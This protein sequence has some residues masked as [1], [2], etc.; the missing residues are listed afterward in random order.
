MTRYICIHG[1]FYQPPRENPWLE[2]VE[3]QD[4]ALPFH[5]WNERIT[6]ECYAPNAKSRLM[7]AHGKVRDI[8]S[9]YAKINFNFGP[10]LLAW[11]EKQ[12]P[13]AYKEII[14]S[15][16]ESM[17]NFGGHPSAIAQVYNHMIM[18][19]ANNRDKET[20]VAWG[21]RDYEKRF[22]C[23]PEGMWLAETAVDTPT[24]EVLAAYGIKYTILSQY[25][26]KR[27]RKSHNAEWIDAS[28]GRLDP[29]MPYVQ[30]LPSGRQIALFF[31][32]GPIS[33]GIA[34]DGLL[35]DG[36]KLSDRLLGA[37]VDSRKHPQLVHI[38][39]DGETYGH[40][41]Q[42]GE[43]AL[44]FAIDH[45]ERNKLAKFVNY[46]QFLELHPP[47]AE[48]EIM[49]NSSWS[50]AH[51]VERWRSNCGCNTGGRPSW[52]QN[53]RAPLRAALDFLRDTVALSFETH[54]KQYLRNPWFARDSY[55]DVMLDRS[56]DNIER[57][58]A[59]HA[60]KQLS[61]NEKSAVLKLLELQRH[62]MLM[63]TSCGW[64]FDELG[65]IETVQC[66]QYAG[67]VVQ[68]AHELFPE[69]PKLEED[70]LQLLVKAKGNTQPLT[71]GAV[72]Y[73]TCV[74]PACLDFLKVAAHHAVA[75]IFDIPAAE[76]DL[77]SYR[78]MQDPP[79]IREAGK[80]TF[81]LGK[82]FIINT[83]TLEKASVEFGALHFGDHTITAGVRNFV[84]EHSQKAL[85]EDALGA[86]ERLDFPAVL[87]VFEKHFGH[88]SYSLKSLFRD[89]QRR[90]TYKLLAETTTDLNA[91]YSKTYLEHYTL[92]RF[93]VE[94]ENRLPRA[95]SSIANFVT[96]LRIRSCLSAEK[97]DIS[98]LR[99]TMEDAKRWNFKYD[100]A[101]FSHLFRAR[102][103][104]LMGEFSEKPHNLENL[105]LLE[106]FI[107][108][109]KTLPFHVNLW[110]VQNDYFCLSRNAYLQYAA[111]G[112]EEKKPP[113]AWFALFQ[114]L[115]DHLSIA[116]P[117]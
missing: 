61:H 23:K 84:C 14:E 24:L 115:G 42:F 74:K 73:K 114:A 109:I 78:I 107:G 4:S 18:P 86:F 2:R 111:A 13:G 56:P 113:E 64:F 85:A 52:N 29:T 76:T 97:L 60:A 71:D 99:S 6:E 100:D 81:V 33:Q 46:G 40:H 82:A 77:Y 26:A 67:R 116:L 50:C 36:H 35:R 88:S 20:Q 43:M 62:T 31:Y 68:L 48:A 32:D 72:V 47:T 75:S 49:E 93:L 110:K 59:E 55:I 5:D 12:A 34:F 1:H 45:I 95:F 57:F 92:M 39:T 25:Q 91:I 37:F 102:I 103:E 80:A 65:G 8:V 63:Y 54:A 3:L 16:K 89:E 98:L 19:L 11:M 112:H 17:R 28:G 38:A 22:G 106:E 10:T 66:I 7:G 30:K 53:W 15:N 108:V 90:I 105:A 9:N 69:L 96:D 70:F 58:L 21:I 83:V 101:E 79:T 44:S 51:G 94:T 87:R 117:Q 27:Y 104:K 41:H